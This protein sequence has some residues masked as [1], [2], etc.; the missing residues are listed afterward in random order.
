M[1]PQFT[2]PQDFS[3]T[4]LKKELEKFPNKKALGLDK[5]ANK[6]LKEVYKKLVLYLIEVF[7]VIMHFR[8]YFKIKKSITIVA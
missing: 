4:L 3:D 5:I 2:I 6:V 8:Y 1:L 7:T